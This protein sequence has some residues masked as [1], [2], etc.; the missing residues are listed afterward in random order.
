MA[1]SY[2]QSTLKADLNRGINN[3]LGMLADPQATINEAVRMV[4]NDFA[5][6]SRRRRQLLVPNLLNGE[7]QYQC[8]SDL[9]A[10]R[11]IDIPEQGKREDGEFNL[12]PPSQFAEGARVGDIAIDDYNGM[13]ILL[14]RSQASDNS[15]TIDPLSSLTTAPS[16]EWQAFGGVDNLDTDS[17]NF[18][19]G[20]GSITFD[21]DATSSTTAGIFNSGLD[22]IDLSA[23]VGKL[24]SSFSYALITSATNITNFKLRLGTSASAYYEF[25]VTAQ[26]D[27]TAF[28]SGWN[29]LRFDLSSYT[30]AGGIAD[31]T[32]ITYGALFMTKTTGKVSELGYAFNYLE[33]RK[34]KYAYV[35]YYSKFGWQTTG[36]SYIENSS[37]TSDVLV[38]DTDEYDLFVLKA[39]ALAAR[40][41]DLPQATIDAKDK[42]YKDAL[43]KYKIDNPSEEKYQISTYWDYGSRTSSID[44]NDGQ[45]I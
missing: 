9:D 31:A 15:T 21:I 40:E 38:A 14:V 10:S 42:D 12:V 26:A 3:K 6:R 16:G 2:T 27:G 1:Y 25:T 34:G 22:H 35:K 43:A 28:S 17:D 13:R 23:F 7:A 44:D 5:L 30:T 32:D 4:N 41:T 45:I 11:I 37:A 36:G 19:K 29:P 33:V 24:S 20:T 8:P 39:R 18:I